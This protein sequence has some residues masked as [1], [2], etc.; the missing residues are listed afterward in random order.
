MIVY[1]MIMSDNT[2]RQL[3]QQLHAITQNGG[4]F[5]PD[6]NVHR[7]QTLVQ[8]AQQAQPTRIIPQCPGLNRVNS[9]L[10]GWTVPHGSSAA[11][12]TYC[13]RCTS[14]LGIAGNLFQSIDSNCNCDS[15][16]RKNKADN[17]IINISFWEPK[18][19]KFYDTE[20]V[21][22]APIP[23]FIVKI[24]SGRN[25]CILLQSQ[26]KQS[27]TYRYE[28]EHIRAV[29]DEPYHVQPE[30][31]PFVHDSTFITDKHDV[32]Y[33]LSY[34][35]SQN[36]GWTLVENQNH[37]VKPGD[38]MTIS[39]HIYN[40]KKHD[41]MLDSGRDFGRYTL[42]NSKTIKPKNN[43][44][45][46]KE[47]NDYD[48]RSSLCL[49][50]REFER[51]TK[52]PMRMRFIFITD[53]DVPDRSDKILRTVISNAIKDT[54]VQVKKAASD[55]SRYRKKYQSNIELL[56]VAQGDLDKNKALLE[57]LN[58]FLDQETPSRS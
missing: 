57:S 11:N 36:P 46:E 45:L 15:F 52:N 16:L 51:F 7:V 29:Q 24:P 25:F 8:Q 22:G 48:K 10:Y 17:G 1:E 35:D 6:G 9:R 3:L 44:K 30:S 55:V 34:I 14:E 43:R 12:E 31:G 19:Y 28:T 42:T 58:E 40:I 41:F 27:Q 38:S 32:K 37:I 54:N 20:V 18:L 23:T 33:F 2:T 53:P 39:I 5:D 26:N 50:S 21:E 4:I 47:Q 13:E 49:A 56:D